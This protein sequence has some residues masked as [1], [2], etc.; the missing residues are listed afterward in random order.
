M[1]NLCNFTHPCMLQTEGGKDTLTCKEDMS[2][3]DAEDFYNA[4]DKELLTLVD[5]DFFDIMPLSK[6]K[7]NHKLIPMTWSFKRKHTPSGELLKHKA[8]LCAHGGRQRCGIDFWNICAPVVN[9]GTVRLLLTLSSL[10]GCK[11]RHIDYVLAFTQAEVDADVYL[12]PPPGYFIKGKTQE[13]YCLK[14]KK[15][16]C[17][18]KQ[19]SANWHELLRSGLVK[20][21]FRPSTVDPCLFIND[22]CIVV[23]YVDDCLMFAKEDKHVDNL[24]SSLSGQFKLTDEG[25]IHAHLGIEFKH[26]NGNRT[27]MSQPCLIERL[28]ELLKLNNDCKMHDT[29]A[30]KI[31]MQ[32]DKSKKK[33]QDWNYRSAIGM[34]N[35][36][37]STTRP[38]ILQ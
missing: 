37:A 9:W 29:P 33:S 4:M 22:Q 35:Y 10:K 3:P 2:A 12:R 1:S 27:Q 34:L 20:R 7:P 8:R 38:D 17:D 18:A 11:T 14:L 24:M 15:N 32:A 16:C 36:I 5:D 30:I 23:T 28:L 19:A 31:L 26:L 25:P 13:D 6:M 21:G